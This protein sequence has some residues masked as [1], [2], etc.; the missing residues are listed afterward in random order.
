MNRRRQSPEPGA[1][2]PLPFP[3]S[4]WSTRRKE[5]SHTIRR[6]TGWWNA[7]LFLFEKRVDPEDILCSRLAIP[8][9]IAGQHF[10]S[11][12]RPHKTTILISNSQNKDWQMTMA[13]NPQNRIV[14]T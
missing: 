7:Q 9:T 1:P 6:F 12:R 3:P 10:L 8:W 13:I 14:T 4:N 5:R 2:L 11:H